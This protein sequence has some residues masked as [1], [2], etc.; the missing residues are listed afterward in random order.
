[1][2]LDQQKII[3][4][5]SRRLEAISELQKTEGWALFQA[6]LDGVLAGAQYRVE[7]AK[8]PYEAWRHLAVV[9]TAKDLKSWTDRE[10]AFAKEAIEVAKRK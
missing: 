3:D 1:M 8:D 7:T 5:C 9:K 4:D 2:S 10:I 6:V